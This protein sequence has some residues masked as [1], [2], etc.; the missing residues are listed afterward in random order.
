M[1]LAKSSSG[2]ATVSSSGQSRFRSKGA[3][4]PTGKV[5]PSRLAFLCDYAFANSELWTSG[6]T[7]RAGL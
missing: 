3:E 1:N 5:S 6:Q 2:H 7:L 4:V